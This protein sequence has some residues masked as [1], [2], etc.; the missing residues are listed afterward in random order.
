MK[1]ELEAL[2]KIIEDKVAE[3]VVIEPVEEIKFDFTRNEMKAN[4]TF[5]YGE[6][7]AISI[8]YAFTHKESGDTVYNYSVWF[9]GKYYNAPINGFIVFC[10]SKIQGLNA[11]SS[12]IYNYL[13]LHFPVESP[14]DFSGHNNIIAD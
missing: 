1:N 14:V 2:N 7:E 8:M 5:Q 9:N 3:S 13:K 6:V 10:S 12:E 4:I 11:V